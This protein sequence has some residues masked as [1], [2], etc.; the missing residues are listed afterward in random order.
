M[1]ICG[2]QKTTLI[3]YPGKIACV[4]FLHGCN[5]KCGY[6]Y[7]SELVIHKPSG[8]FSE[9]EIIN[10]LKKRK[11]LLEGVCITGGEPLLSLDKLFLKKIKDLGYFIKIDTN[12]TNP[13]KLNELIIDGL[14]DYIAMD[15]K[16]NKEDYEK[17]V[18]SKV[19]LDKIEQSMKLIVNFQN[20]EFRTTVLSPFH[21]EE[22][23]IKMLEWLKKV[24][25]KKPNRYFLQG[26]KN[27]GNFI[28]KSFEKKDP[29]SLEHLE[30]LKKIA[31]NYFIEVNIRW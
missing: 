2:L 29:T 7:N 19:N 26:F 17:I 6:C 5:F 30:N 14:V 12:G 22:K 3:D 9:E 4:I 10:F 24:V 15:L 18:N 13:E 20:Y 21:T 31:S 8:I 25:N 11:D 16:S 28:D 27:K 23:I 1:N